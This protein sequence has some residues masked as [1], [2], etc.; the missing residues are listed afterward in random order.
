MHVF[1]PGLGTFLL[2]YVGFA[3]NRPNFLQK[4]IRKCGKC[5]K[6]CCKGSDRY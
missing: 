2:D 4:N 3:Y 5:F 1:I 6:L